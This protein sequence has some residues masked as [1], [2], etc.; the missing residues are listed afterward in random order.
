[1][2]YWF[3]GGSRHSCLICFMLLN[4]SC[5]IF[6]GSLAVASFSI[7]CS[8]C[9]ACILSMSIFRSMFSD[10]VLVGLVLS[11]MWV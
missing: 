3:V 6:G 2:C 10:S 4:T 7:W 5:L 8:C 11:A 9:S 1:M